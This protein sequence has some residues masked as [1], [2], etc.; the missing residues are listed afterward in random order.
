MHPHM[1]PPT[2]YTIESFLTRS[3]FK[4]TN[5]TTRKSNTHHYRSIKAIAVAASR[6][7]LGMG[8]VVVFATNKRGNQG[9]IG[10]AHE[11]LEQIYGAC[12]SPAPENSQTTFNWVQ[13]S[14]TWR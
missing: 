10:L 13:P 6:K 14:S 8:A 2:R 5:P 7:A 4:W 9:V 12:P 3:D 11:L 1:E